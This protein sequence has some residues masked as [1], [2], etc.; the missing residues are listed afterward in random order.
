MND[1]SLT[2]VWQVWVFHWLSHAVDLEPVLLYQL[3]P[4]SSFNTIMKKWIQQDGLCLG[5]YSKSKT[6]VGSDSLDIN[7][8]INYHFTSIQTLKN[9]LDTSRFWEKI[10]PPPMMGKILSNLAPSLCSPFLQTDVTPS[11]KNFSSHISYILFRQVANMVFST[12]YPWYAWWRDHYHYDCTDWSRCFSQWNRTH[13]CNRLDHVSH[14]L[15]H[16]FKVCFLYIRISN[17]Q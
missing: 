3:L 1:H 13:L 15:V 4:C 10:V 16:V 17:F 8:R 6:I 9:D 11:G 2:T 12:W 7:D 5:N 14:F